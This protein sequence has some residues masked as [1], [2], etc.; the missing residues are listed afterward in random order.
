[1]EKAGLCEIVMWENGMGRYKKIIDCLTT[2]NLQLTLKSNTMKNS[3]QNYKI[4]FKT[5][6]YNIKKYLDFNIL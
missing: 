4:F 5:M 3:L 6:L 2:T 1:M